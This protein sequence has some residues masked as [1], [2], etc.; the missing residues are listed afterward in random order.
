MTDTK[1]M[2]KKKMNYETTVNNYTATNLITQ[3]NGY[4]SRFSL[5]TLNY[6][7]IENQIRLMTS[8]EKKL[9]I[10]PTNQVNSTSHLET[11]PM[12][13]EAF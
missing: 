3:K 13:L 9:V 12:I 11:I 2:Q 10:W 8:K 4:I 6:E 1:E 7:K 5:P